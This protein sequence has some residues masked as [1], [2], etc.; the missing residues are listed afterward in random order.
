MFNINTSFFL[1]SQLAKFNVQTA[2][3][4]ELRTQTLAVS[5]WHISGL[6]RNKPVA[7]PAWHLVMQVQI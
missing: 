5:S 1:A 7:K 2:Q 6:N 3:S 4:R